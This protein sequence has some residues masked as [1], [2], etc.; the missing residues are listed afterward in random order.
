MSRLLRITAV[1]AALLLKK[2][3][4]AYQPT[5]SQR[6]YGVKVEP[7]DRRCHAVSERGFNL[8]FLPA[9]PAA[10]LSLR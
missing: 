9:L 5:V 7:T 8:Y 4:L 6:R 10:L 1:M 3:A 2:S